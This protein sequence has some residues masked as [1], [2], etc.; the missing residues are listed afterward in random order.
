[1]LRKLLI[2]SSWMWLLVKYTDLRLIRIA[3]QSPTNLRRVPLE[4]WATCDNACF[5]C[6]IASL[7]VWPMPN[8]CG[9]YFVDMGRTVNEVSI[10]HGAR[11]LNHCAL[12]LEYGMMQK[13]PDLGSASRRD[14]H[15]CAKDRIRWHG[16][17][18][19]SNGFGG[20]SDRVAENERPT[21]TGRK[22]PVAL[23]P[24][25]R[26]LPFRVQ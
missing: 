24:S 3:L 25:G 9:F 22:C 17:S 12:C 10:L 26:S 2:I 14:L 21:A 1:M 19:G 23:S 16:R 15:P 13:L 5:T 7:P 4:S 11:R 20:A 18:I 8:G 6:T